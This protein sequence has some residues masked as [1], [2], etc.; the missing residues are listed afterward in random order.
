[1]SD[2]G[3]S[4]VVRGSNGLCLQAPPDFNIHPGFG[5]DTSKSVKV[6]S[7]S[8]DGVSLAWSNMASVKIARLNQGKW[9]VVHDLPQAKVEYQNIKSTTHFYIDPLH[10]SSVWIIMMSHRTYFTG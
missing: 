7:W 9:V 2:S 8:R 4:L 5:A 3:P 1:M 6:F 10:T